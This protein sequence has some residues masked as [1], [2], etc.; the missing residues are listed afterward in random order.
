[1]NI[2][3]IET[4]CVMNKEKTVIISCPHYP[5][6]WNEKMATGEKDYFNWSYASTEHVISKIKI[7]YEFAS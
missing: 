2:H 3:T 1:M 5:Q 4:W 6:V 7:T